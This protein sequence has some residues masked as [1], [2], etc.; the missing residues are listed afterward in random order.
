MIYLLFIVF[1]IMLY[2]TFIKFDKDII[3][4]PVVLVS[5]YTLSI[6]C[7]IANVEKWGIV[8]H[9]NTFCVLIYGTLL[10][11]LTAYFIKKYT[12]NKNKLIDYNKD[13]F[14]KI[15][16]NLVYLKIYCIF[17][18]VFMLLWLGMIYYIISS[19]F[20]INSYSD[21]M[22]NFRNWSTNNTDW[23]N[24]YIYVFMIQIASITNISAYLFLYILLFN[25]FSNVKEY[26]KYLIFSIILS[27]F[28]SV[29]SGG[30]LSMLAI[31]FAGI[32]FY[33]VFYY[34]KY[35]KKFPIN[36]KVILIFI[37]SLVGGAVLFILSLAVARGGVI[38]IGNF[39]PYI[40]FYVGGSIEGLNQFLQN[41]I[42]SSKIFGKETFYSIN[43]FLI[44]F[45]L[46]DVEPYK[47]H[48][49]FREAI[50][51]ANIGNIYTA[52]RS[53]IY[54]FGY[55]GLTVLP[56]IFSAII[57]YLY[58]T[59]IKIIKKINIYLLFYS[60]IFWTLFFDFVRC[61]FFTGV[62]SIGMIKQFLIL[63]VLT[64][65]FIKDFRIKDLWNNRNLEVKQ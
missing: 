18:C 30:R 40:T 24:N 62:F 29:L 42:E 57:N 1:L 38:T 10:F 52:Y 41:P 48:L 46:Y 56:V 11:V 23:I 17:Q 25:F 61:F 58:Y 19:M 9:S 36:K 55:F 3:A 43:F 35:R 47:V 21:M 22:G 32:M 37:S 60:L 12:F 6:I 7:A 39:I 33:M 63:I 16:I 65:I 34:Q 53:Y 51:G 26:N 2:L 13:Y 14:N 59:A 64:A 20:Q 45:G 49:E 50:T 31:I 5:G 54:D 15:S 8:L 44:R 27:I 4:P 28:Q